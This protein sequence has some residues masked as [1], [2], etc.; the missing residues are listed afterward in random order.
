MANTYET[1]ALVHIR[2]A[3]APS[4]DT[5]EANDLVRTY[6]TRHRAEEDRDLVLRIAPEMKT[7]IIE[8]EHIDS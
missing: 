6:A 3:V 2:S 1:F 8:I 4:G 7:A 5:I